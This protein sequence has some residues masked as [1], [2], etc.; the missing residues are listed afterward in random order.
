MKK[1]LSRKQRV[2]SYGKRMKQARM[3]SYENF[4][5]DVYGL[6]EWKL[7][8]TLADTLAHPQ[9]C[10]QC[11]ACCNRYRVE[12]TQEDIDREPRLVDHSF[13]PDE[14][15]R[16]YF[17]TSDTA[18]RILFVGEG[19]RCAFYDEAVGCTIYETR[20]A[21]CREY[22]P[23]I[24]N[25][26]RAQIHGWDIARTRDEIIQNLLDGIHIFDVDALKDW[27]WIGIAG[28]LVP[29]ICEVGVKGQVGTVSPR[30]NDPAPDFL[31]EVFSLPEG[32]LIADLPIFKR[33]GDYLVGAHGQKYFEY[34]RTFGSPLERRRNA[35]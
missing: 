8:Q 32:A 27:I 11:G 14:L 21:E 29:F 1:T 24:L 15:S 23:S 33:D 10:T 20:P 6:P 9:E 25:C 13:A 12:V 4:M 16:A 35:S 34:V 3:R 7:F 2:D 22:I 26:R 28:L 18:V 31:R 17:N 19:K 5:D 30:Y